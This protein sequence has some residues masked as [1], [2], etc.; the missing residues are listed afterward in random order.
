M[1]ETAPE[2]WDR[3]IGLNLRSA[4][5]CARAVLPGM[6]EAGWGRIVFVS[7]RSARRGLGRNAA[8]SVAKAGLGPL[9]EAISEECRDVNVTA[10]VVAPST[11]DTP[12]NRAAWPDA[13]HDR[14][15]APGNVAAAISFLTS[16]AA[17]DVR[18]AWIPVFGSV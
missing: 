1:D 15:V 6:L 4:F 14:W 8:Y 3:L 11:I 17:G 2:D 10:N 18:G 13:R 16:E 9:A 12:Q 5:V 7:S